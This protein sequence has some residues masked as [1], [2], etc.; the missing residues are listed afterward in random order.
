M[1]ITHQVKCAQV[2]PYVWSKSA[3]TMYS[4]FF[5]CSE[6]T[7]NT[8]PFMLSHGAALPSKDIQQS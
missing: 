7:V 6:Q 2:L 8:P 1:E 4:P 3:Y 5:P